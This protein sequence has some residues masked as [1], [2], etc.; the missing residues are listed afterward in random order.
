MWNHYDENGP[1]TNN[2]V[3]G[4]HSKLQK[5]FGQHPNLW[6]FITQLKEEEQCQDVRQRRLEAN[7]LVERNRAKVDVERD[8]KILCFKLEFEQKKININ[9]LIEKLSCLTIDFDQN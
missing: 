4:Y 3:E 9:T 5:R 8:F 7:K 6:K 1:R 2:D